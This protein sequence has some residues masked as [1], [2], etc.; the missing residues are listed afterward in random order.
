M[1]FLQEGPYGDAM[2]NATAQPEQ[3]AVR[4]WMARSRAYV[5]LVLRNYFYYK[6]WYGTPMEDLPHWRSGSHPWMR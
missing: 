1:A 2:L 4:D 5:K 3:P 6:R